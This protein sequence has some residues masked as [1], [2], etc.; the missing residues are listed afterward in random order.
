[1][2]TEQA[3]ASTNPVIPDGPGVRRQQKRGSG[4]RREISLVRGGLIGLSQWA[5]LGRSVSLPSLLQI[6][7]DVNVGGQY[8][9][10]GV[11]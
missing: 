10:A 3:F 8:P 5:R 6:R 4:L 2:A 1:V 9:S 7:D 11:L